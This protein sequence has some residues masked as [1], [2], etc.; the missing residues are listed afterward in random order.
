[1]ISQRTNAV[2]IAPNEDAI[3]RHRRALLVERNEEW[4]VSVWRYMT[5]ET[6]AKVRHA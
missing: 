1:M 3:V 4:A 5:L 2:G 6:L